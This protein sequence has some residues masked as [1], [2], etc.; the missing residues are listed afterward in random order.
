M[1][2]DEE[3]VHVEDR[4]RMD[5]H[6]ASARCASPSSLQGDGVREQVAVRQHRSLAAPGGAARVEDRGEVVARARR[7]RVAV[8][9][10]RRPFEQAAAAIVAEG[11]DEGRPGGEGELGRPDEI[12]RRADEDGG[13][14]VADEVADLV[15]L[16]GGVE[17]Q[18]D[19]AGAQHGQVE[20]QRLDRFLDLHRD[21]AR[22]RQVE[23]IEQVGEHRRRPLEVA[24]G[25]DQA[26]LDRLDGGAVKVARKAVAQ[27][28][29]EVGVAGGGCHEEGMQ[30]ERWRR[31]DRRFLQASAGRQSGRAPARASG[32][33]AIRSEARE[34]AM[35]RTMRPTSASAS[36]STSRRVFSSAARARRRPRRSPRGRSTRIAPHGESM[37]A[38]RTF[39][40]G[41]LAGAARRPALA[42]RRRRPHPR[43]ALRGGGQGEGQGPLEDDQGR[44]RARRPLT[45][46][47]RS[48]AAPVAGEPDCARQRPVDRLAACW[49]P[50]ACARRSARAARPRSSLCA[51]HWRAGRLGAG[52]RAGAGRGRPRRRHP[53]RH[54]RPPRRRRRRTPRRPHRH[55]H[56]RRRPRRRRGPAS[57]A[58]ADHRRPPDDV[59]ERRN[60]TTAKIIVG[61][62]EIDRFGDSTLGDVLKRLPGV[63][64]QGRPGRGGAIRLRGLGNGY[65]QILLDGERVP[66]GFS[67]DSLTPDQ[68]ERIEILRAP[69]A[70]TGARAIAGTINIITRGGYTRRVN[71]VRLA[72]AYENGKVQPSASWTRNFTAGEFIVNYSLSAFHIDRDNSSTTT[73]I[74][75]RL[76]DGTVTLEQVDRRAAARQRRRRPRD[77]TNPVAARGRRRFGDAD[78]DPVR[79]PLPLP[80]RRHADADHRCRRAALRHRRDDRAHRHVAGAPEQR[81]D[82]SLRPRGARRVARRRR[83]GARAG[84]QLS[85]RV[86]QRQ[87]VAHAR[88]NEP[89]ARHDDHGERQARRA[90]PRGAQPRLRDRARIES[91]RRHA[92]EPAERAADPDRLL[93]QHQRL[94][95]APGR[96][97]AGRM[98]PLRALGRAR[99]SALGGHPHAR[100]G[101][102]G[103][104]PRPSTRAASGRRFSMRCGSPTRK[105]AT[106]CASA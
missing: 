80:P 66:P 68:I 95:D 81:M 74:D 11:E 83:P 46:P 40:R 50:D 92:D 82:A 104:A 52:R 44:A 67:L 105:G 26:A 69:T 22:R 36:T 75:R 72:A 7:R 19:V 51:R 4:Q 47:T 55:P 5:Q 73:T 34:N 94:D 14:G 20:E 61:R 17:R 101:R 84:E 29:E 59:Q 100:L 27:G 91:P 86:H 71:D 62:E 76:D 98:E 21:P 77:G 58:G 18:V 106:R 32:L 1:R 87:R 64:I 43:A 3:A 93:R 89:L 33:P 49:M 60:S 2:G 96:L 38:S 6:V 30:P 88:G 97:R 16:V 102:G 45:P 12:L 48:G 53:H 24:P 79:E 63:T 41:H 57:R 28:D 56:R 65:T 42:P 103:P 85:H 13:L 78:A 10:V 99:G 23:R 31:A 54:C 35:P 9:E 90:G 15:A 37:T 39:A 70:E 8:G 25:V